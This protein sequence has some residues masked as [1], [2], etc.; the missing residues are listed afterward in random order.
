MLLAALLGF[1]QSD[2]KPEAA[3]KKSYAVRWSPS[4]L[5]FGKIGLQGEYNFKNKRSLTLSV[6]LPSTKSIDIEMGDDTR[7]LSMK[8]FSTMAGYRLYMGK[9]TMTGVYFEPYVKYLANNAETSFIETSGG[10]QTMYTLNSQYSGVGLGAQLGVQF[11]IAKRFTFD[12]YFLGL[13]GNLSN[14]QITLQDVSSATPWS[15]QDAK[16]AENELKEGV[17]DIPIIGKKIRIT[18]DAG[19]KTVSS[20]YSGFL[21]GLRFGLSFGYRF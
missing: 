19:T 17:E 7:Q 2:N 3:S 12:F 14:H 6:G 18:A 4:S 5:Y 15:S 21:P 16:D 9:K 10:K 20:H 8:T 11:M 13:E 1:A